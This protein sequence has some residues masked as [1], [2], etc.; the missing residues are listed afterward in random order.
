MSCD[1]VITSNNFYA[2]VALK[3][4]YCLFSH[5]ALFQDIFW[6]TDLLSDKYLYVLFSYC[7]LQWWKSLGRFLRALTMIVSHQPMISSSLLQTDV[8]VDYEETETGT[9]RT[10]GW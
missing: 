5:I 2:R 4:F 7:I 1:L 6:I 9:E 8:P 10:A 3:Y